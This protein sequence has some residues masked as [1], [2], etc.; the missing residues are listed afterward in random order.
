MAFNLKYVKSDVDLDQIF[1]QFDINGDGVLNEYEMGN[2]CSACGLPRAYA[3]LNDLL[4]KHFDGS[5]LF[6]FKKFIKYLEEAQNDYPDFLRKL[7]KS[8][9]DDKSKSLTFNEIGNLCLTL[10]INVHVEQLY[11]VVANYDSNHSGA[12]DMEEF[13]R[14]F[15]DLSRNMI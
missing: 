7:F 3:R 12:L 2:L 8:L 15:T 11:A 4:G 14:F 1:R 9:D 13:V 10:G 5:P 6:K